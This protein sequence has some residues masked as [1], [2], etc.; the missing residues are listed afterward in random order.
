MS[1][2]P[3]SSINSESKIDGIIN[4]YLERLHSVEHSENVSNIPT[5]TSAIAQRRHSSNNTIEN[6]V[7]TAMITR[8]H[9]PV[10][11]SHSIASDEDEIKGS[12]N[13]LHISDP[14]GIVNIKEHGSNRPSFSSMFRH[15][16]MVKQ[17]PTL[18]LGTLDNDYIDQILKEPTLVDR[19][20]RQDKKLMDFICFG[21]F[22]IEEDTENDFEDDNVV[23]GG[24][25][26]WRKVYHID[27]IIEVML[28]NL[29][30][31]DGAYPFNCDNPSHLDETDI[32]NDHLAE[33]LVN[34]NTVRDEK[35]DLEFIPTGDNNTLDRYAQIIR[36]SDI[37]ILNIPT[38]QKIILESF[39]RME[40]LWS[41]IHHPK[42]VSE[43][44]IQL[45]IFLKIQDGLLANGRNPYLNFI[46][47]KHSLVQDIFD[48]DDLS[49]VFDFL[50]RLICTDKINDTTGII[51]ILEVQGLMK[52]CM[53]YFKGSI[54]SDR[55][56]STVYEFLKQLIG[57]SVNIPM[58]DISIGPN[59]LTRFLV[60]ENTVETLVQILLEQKGSVLCNIVV[61]MIELIRKNNSD[62]DS[63]SLLETTILK[64]P[65]NKRD[66]LYLG[67]LLKIF[68]RYLPRLLNIIWSIDYPEN[69]SFITQT[70]E[71]FK[72][73]GLVRIK[74]VELIA[75]LLHCSNMD[76]MN[77]KTSELIAEERQKCRDSVNKEIDCL[78][79]DDNK[80]TIS[81]IEGFARLS[82]NCSAN[83]NK[84]NYSSDNYSEPCYGKPFIS[85][86]NNEK[87]RKMKT[88]GDDFKIMLFDQEAIPRILKIFLDHPWN[89]FWHNV[90]FDIIQ[91]LLNGRID[92]T[93]NPFL[94]YSLFFLNDS[95]K[96]NPTFT[97]DNDSADF[98]IIQ[99]FIICAYKRCY[100]YYIKN[101]MVLGYNGHM[102]LIVEDLTAF[103][104]NIETK[105]ISLVIFDSLQNEK[106][107]RLS[108]EILVM[109]K[110]MCIKILGGGERIEDQNG[111]ITLQIYDNDP[112]TNLNENKQQ[113]DKV[114]PDYPTQVTLIDKIGTLF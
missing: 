75:E 100:Q 99:D 6:A 35:E 29:D 50:L 101:S 84:N 48:H 19:L 41:L 93:Y 76:L 104:K 58:N 24:D 16:D 77:L 32:R 98:N 62:F 46:R 5:T 64:N 15:T 9:S 40:K 25:D 60:L 38:I 70:G 22:Y 91:Q 23:I 83:G 53:S 52:K 94:V 12:M 55:Q 63:I 61:L 47:N 74:I 17:S 67:N 86:A 97:Q 106:W 65:P 89:N 69:E 108:E 18:S 30:E 34:K 11:S 44:S 102:L 8:S 4:N 113:P 13:H 39:D 21:Y 114:V 105:S 112:P 31:I 92:S 109:T 107:I 88:I 71:E 73:I 28:K 2:W 87:I 110:T 33:Y 103:S 57:I 36:I 72:K 7:T 10:Y 42:I 51:D 43:N 111:N 1:F 78:L 59:N 49:N 66:P 37:I 56:I 27:Y 68:T 3:F 54:Y 96:Y 80:T 95:R 79:K 45:T 82:S 90:S 14:R 81:L 26:I 85:M 20:V